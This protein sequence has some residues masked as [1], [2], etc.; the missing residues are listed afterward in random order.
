MA[1][2][3]CTT[4]K[5]IAMH[6]E[7][8]NKA[9][10]QKNY[11]QALS[12]YEQIISGL[13]SK[14]K[15]AD[16]E[17]YSKAG[18]SALALNKNDKALTYLE[19]IAFNDNADESTIAA[20]AKVYRNID[21][22]SKELKMLEMYVAKFKAEKKN[23]EITARLFHVY[24]EIENWEKGLLL[25]GEMSEVEKKEIRHLES[26][27]KIQQAL[28][29]FKTAD[30][31]AD[32]ILSLEKENTIAMEYYARKYYYRA[33]NLYQMEMEA[34]EK[35]KTNRQYKILLKKL[36]I[37]SADFKKSRDYYEKLFQINKKSEYAKYLGNIYAR[38]NNN[39]K[40]KY[41]RNLSIGEIEN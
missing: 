25:W 18:K 11:T 32:E 10:Q 7:S 26:Y 39:K 24:I 41:C 29:N 16:F 35:N 37:V 36:K 21:N 13:E 12:D 22:L 4:G 5:Q 40:A 19:K 30:K 20:L 6:T 28:E 8:G 2:F 31:T 1:I 23:D 9:F 33:E 17:V 3:S 34:Y 38:L 15:R 14:G 27:L